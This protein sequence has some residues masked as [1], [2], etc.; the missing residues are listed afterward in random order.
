MKTRNLWMLLMAVVLL[1]FNSCKKETVDVTDLLKTVPSSAAGVVV[2]NMEGILEDAGCKIKDHVVT[3]S[4]EVKG[5][6]EKS[7]SSMKDEYML[8]FSGD[9]GI[10]PKG[11]VVFYDTNRT[12]LTVALYDVKKFC[13]YIEKKTGNSFT[14]ESGGVKVCGQVAVK[15]SQAW[16]CMVSHKNIDADAISA[17][18]SLGMSQSFLVT[19]IGEKLLVEEDD[20]RGWA[21]INTFANEMLSRQ[22][23]SMFSLGLGFLFEDAESVMFKTDFKKGELEMEAIVLN[24]N[25]KPAKYLLPSDKV[26]VNTLKSLGATCDAMMAFT[27]NSK[28][29]KKFEQ[30]G[31]AFGGVLF[32]NLGEM[33]KNVDGTVGIVSSGNGVGES[34]NGVVSTKGEVSKSLKDLISNEMGAVKEDG[35]YL[36]FSKGD[37]KGSL[38][39]EDC[40]NELKGCCLGFVLDPSGFQS[41]GYGD[42]APTGLKEVVFK[43]NPESGG[44]EVEI[45]VK[46]TDPKENAL[47]TILRNSK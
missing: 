28:L 44:L 26:D 15:G 17:Y 39:V 16:V 7:S 25:G 1:G 5:L 23:R 12:F 22:D 29:I 20:I 38:S 36:R 24:D 41:V 3:P 8:L 30:L 37:V 13:D 27:L 43:L 19:P 33:F 40:A 46:T 9:T 21:M 32:G 42:A 2:I 18:A 11:A 4:D 10:E 6:I 35:K 47:L 14:E 34:I 45:D 31:S